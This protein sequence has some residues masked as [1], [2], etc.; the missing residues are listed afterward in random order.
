MTAKESPV[1]EVK[2]SIRLKDSMLFLQPKVD[3]NIRSWFNSVVLDIFCMFSVRILF[4][5][6]KLFLFFFRLSVD[7]YE[8]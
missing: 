6:M 1:S 5:I 8:F 3:K 2:M 7:L 4:Q